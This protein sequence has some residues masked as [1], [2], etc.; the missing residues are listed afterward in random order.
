MAKSKVWPWELV[1]EQVLRDVFGVEGSCSPLGEGLGLGRGARLIKTPK[2]SIWC[3]WEAFLGRKWSVVTTSHCPRVLKVTS[4]SQA[5][6]P[7]ASLASLLPGCY[8]PL[9]M[10]FVSPMFINPCILQASRGSTP[11]S[12]HV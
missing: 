5:P 4:C 8:D 6:T 1:M 12:S 9:L 10:T 3:D 11:L 7:I 2:F